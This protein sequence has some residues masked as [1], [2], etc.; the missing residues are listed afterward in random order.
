V[1]TYLKSGIK[2]AWLVIP[3]METI[4]V[5]HSPQKIKAFTHGRV[6]D[7]VSGIELDMDA[8]FKRRRKT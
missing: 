6:L 7:P 4:Y 8:I 1:K 3:T 2:S 5:I